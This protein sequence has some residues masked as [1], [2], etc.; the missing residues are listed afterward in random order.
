M[1][2]LPPLYAVY[3]QIVSSLLMS[4][5]ELAVKITALPDKVNS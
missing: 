2:C 1:D 4:K 5:R 3:A